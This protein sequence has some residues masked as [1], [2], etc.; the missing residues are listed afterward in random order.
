M[1]FSKTFFGYFC[2][3]IAVSFLGFHSVV[4]RQLTQEN[5]N[6]EIIAA[7][8]LLIGS[9][10]ILLVALILKLFAKKGE[11]KV[12]QI[13]RDFFFW[14]TVIGLALNFILFHQG[15]KFTYASNAILIET[16]SPIFVLFFLIFFIPNRIAFLKKRHDLVSRL[17]FIVLAGSV[18]SSLLLSGGA[19]DEFINLDHKFMGDMMEFL[20]M[21]FYALFF[22]GSNEYKKRN[23]TTSSVATSGQFLFFA[24]LITIA[25]VPFLTDFSDVLKINSRQWMWI[26]ILGFFSTGITYTLWHV[27]SKYLRV[28]SLSLLFSLS[29]VCTV[30]IENLVFGTS[31][32]WNVVVS[33]ILILA[34]SV[35]AELTY[36]EGDKWLKKDTLPTAN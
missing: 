4:I 5:I 23:M 17:V 11:E 28:I 3:L 25:V 20:A 24:A 7:L 8:R 16:F 22:I 19:K 34:A 2:G 18:G 35:L 36:K 14:L 30:I 29:A 1:K 26:F 10:T 6:P 27:A 12:Y 9:V 13:K 33:S 21:L 31:I 15:L 32:T